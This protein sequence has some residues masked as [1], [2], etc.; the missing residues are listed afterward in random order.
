MTVA[1]FVSAILSQMPNV[2][3]RK[4]DLLIH[5]IPL[6]MGI[7]GRVNFNY[8]SYNEATYHNQFQTAFDFVEFNKNLIKSKGSSHYIMVYDP[9]YL[10]FV[11]I[12][13]E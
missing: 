3:K 2:N 10:P 5:L 1:T 4:R 11:S 8:G 6:F 9:S 13:I 7:R 12:S